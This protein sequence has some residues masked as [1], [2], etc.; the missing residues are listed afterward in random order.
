MILAPDEQGDIQEH[1]AR[2]RMAQTEHSVIGEHMFQ[3]GR[4][5][6]DNITSIPEQRVAVPIRNS[7]GASK[8]VFVSS[9]AKL[10][11]TRPRS[12]ATHSTVF[13]LV[14]SENVDIDVLLG[15]HDSGEGM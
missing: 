8:D 7:P 2:M 11:W 12:S 14:P 1:V 15:C 5:C 13:Y 4:I 6:E 10:T 3:D 9:T